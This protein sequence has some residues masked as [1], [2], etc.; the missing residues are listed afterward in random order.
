MST[1][2]QMVCGGSQV[3]G[4]TEWPIPGFAPLNLLFCPITSTLEHVSALLSRE[5]AISTQEGHRQQASQLHLAVPSASTQS[6]VLF[7]SVKNWLLPTGKQTQTQASAA[8]PQA[9]Q[10]LQPGRVRKEERGGTPLSS[11]LK[12]P[13]ASLGC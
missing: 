6:P 10:T 7:S 12:D 9:C 2:S 11:A 4:A 1:W 8:G 13:K 5:V 3:W